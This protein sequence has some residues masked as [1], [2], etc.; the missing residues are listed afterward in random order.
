MTNEFKERLRASTINQLTQ[1][2]FRVHLI[3]KVCKNVRQ[4]LLIR[5]KMTPLPSLIVDAH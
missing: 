2:I 5:I 4:R 1:Y 3:C